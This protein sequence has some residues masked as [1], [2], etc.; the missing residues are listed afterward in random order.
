MANTRFGH[1]HVMSK[2]SKELCL[3]LLLLLLLLLFLLVPAPREERWTGEG[4]EMLELSEA[5]E[6]TEEGGLKGPLVGRPE[7]EEEEEE[8]WSGVGAGGWREGA[9]EVEM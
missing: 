2:A 7:K 3:L 8:V 9:L 6:R 4:E 1:T 5:A